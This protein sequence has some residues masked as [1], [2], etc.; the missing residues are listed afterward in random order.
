MGTGAGHG[1]AAAS[2]EALAHAAHL[3]TAQS[4]DPPCWSTC[5]EEAV[6]SFICTCVPQAM[7][8]VEAPLAETIRA[9]YRAEAAR[10]AR[11]ATAS[12]TGKLH[13]RM[14]NEVLPHDESC[15][16]LGSST[17]VSAAE[18]V[19][20]GLKSQL[21]AALLIF[22]LVSP[23]VLYAC[24]RGHEHV[25]SCC[26]SLQV[27]KWATL[28]LP[29]ARHRQSRP[30]LQHSPAMGRLRSQ[31]ARQR[32]RQEVSCRH[33]QASRSRCHMPSTSL[34]CLPRS[35]WALTA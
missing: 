31:P 1:A 20:Q 6:S 2:Q 34:G 11:H 7:Q 13:A 18:A 25:H 21:D 26:F 4:K 17:C 24:T 12:A 9:T 15:D 3:R 5:V 8:A 28:Q 19:L 23:A 30:T 35:P 16:S 33:T 32:T 10:Q 14:Y 29:A 27:H 22:S